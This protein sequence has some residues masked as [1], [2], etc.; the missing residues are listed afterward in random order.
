[1]TSLYDPYSGHPADWMHKAFDTS[2]AWVTRP[3]TREVRITDPDTG[4]QKGSKDERHDLIPS[5]ALA[6]LARVYGYGA[7][8]YDDHNWRKGY[9]WSLSYAAMQRHLRAFWGGE[10][11]DPE[12]GLPHLA[13]A[14]WHCFTLLTFMEEH[15]EKDNRYGNH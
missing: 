4:A 10:D 5:G 12:S 14:A 11:Y 2:P 8:K 1:M 3:D 7:G 6:A 13:H 9:V 15:P